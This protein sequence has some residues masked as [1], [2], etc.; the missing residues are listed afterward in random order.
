M[1]IDA[2]TL[3]RL[4]VLLAAAALGACF[5]H[6][7]RVPATREVGGDRRAVVPAGDHHEVEVLFFHDTSTGHG[8]PHHFPVI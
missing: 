7:Y 1:G 4:G 8:D 5:E 3:Q 2:E 6:A